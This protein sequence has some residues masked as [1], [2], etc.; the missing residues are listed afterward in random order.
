MERILLRTALVNNMTRWIESEIEILKSNYKKL[1]AKGCLVKLNGKTVEQIRSKASDLKLKLDKSTLSKVNKKYKNNFDINRL[2]NIK[3]AEIA[4]ILGY[5]WADGYISKKYNRIALV[6]SKSDG[7]E[8]KNI[9]MT[10]PWLL[11]THIDPIE[12]NHSKLS[13]FFIYDYDIHNFFVC[14]DYLVKSG[15]SPDKI[16]S[17]IPNELKRYWWRGYFDG[18]GTVF[19]RSVKNKKDTWSYGA[20][21]SSCYNQNWEFA[22]DL[23]NFLGINF[24][25]SKFID[26]NKEGGSRIII[27]RFDYLERFYNFIYS[28]MEFGLSRKKKIFENILE[29]KQRKLLESARNKSCQNIGVSKVRSG[30]FRASLGYEGRWMYI[31]EFKTEEEAILA[32]K[33][34]Q[35]ELKLCQH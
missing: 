17:K 16:L 8:V 18:D 32:R 3:E 1:G 24:R 31:G 11:Y 7:D 22:Y 35:L 20:N 6:I 27:S 2:Y 9:L 33:N 5:V 28:G 25:L 30:R 26:K 34:K 29:Y 13:R 15:A 10:L 12:K 19:L 23:A 21:F 14:N 4:Y